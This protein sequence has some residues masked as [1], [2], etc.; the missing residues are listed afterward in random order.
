MEPI[1]VEDGPDLPPL[2]QVFGAARRPDGHWAL[3]KLSPE[4]A[5]PDAA[6][7][8][9]PQ[10][11][12]LETAAASDRAVRAQAAG[13][14][15]C[16]AISS[17]V[18]FLARG[19]VGP[20]RTDAERIPGSDGVAAVRV[21]LHDEGDGDR[22]GDGRS[23]QFRVERL[24]RSATASS[25]LVASP[26]GV[27]PLAPTPPTSQCGARK[28]RASPR[29]CACAPCAGRR[30]SRRW[31]TTRRRAAR[32]VGRR[33]RRARPE[34]RGQASGW[35]P[36]P[37]GWHRE[38]GTTA[39]AVAGI[40]RRTPR[41]E[42]A[43]PGGI[44]LHVALHDGR[45]DVVVVEPPRHVA[46]RYAAGW[47]RPATFGQRRPV[48]EDAAGRQRV[49][50]HP[51]ERERWRARRRRRLRAQRAVAEHADAVVAVDAAPAARW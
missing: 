13:P 34:R 24:E 38:R 49:A 45:V 43:V 12:L 44:V 46:R 41:R 42:V 18:M 40:V 48:G 1:V 35:R 9:G 2:W 17:H 20:F 10:F 19:K 25:R 47:R 36:P 14:I 30:R 11:V 23:Y 33:A 5:S 50:R 51:G 39:T 22:A 21:V 15:R 8:L 29:S 16:E 28:A 3:P 32:P 37:P 26:P 6:L 27:R 4:V 7:H 31:P